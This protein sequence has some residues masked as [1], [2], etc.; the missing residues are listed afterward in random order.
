M[1][2]APGKSI[3]LTF[4]V[5]SPLQDSGL[6]FLQQLNV[7]TIVDFNGATFAE[8]SALL[9]FTDGGPGGSGGLFDAFFGTGLNMF[10]WDF[11]GS[12]IF[13]ATH[14]LTPGTFPIDTDSSAFFKN[15][16]IGGSGA[17]TS[18]TV[19]VTTAAAVPEPASLLLLGMGLLA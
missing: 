15:F 1:F 10:E 2:S 17:F 3:V 7:P 5:S 18:G 9:F 19:E 13:D 16:G 12:Q 11:F 6:G 4:T 14:H 8:I